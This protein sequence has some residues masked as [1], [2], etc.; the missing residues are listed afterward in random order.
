MKNSLSA[1]LPLPPTKKKKNTRLIQIFQ[2]FQT[3]GNHG[4]GR[5]LSKKIIWIL[6]SSRH[7]IFSPIFFFLL[8]ISLPDEN[9]GLRLHQFDRCKLIVPLLSRDYVTS[10]EHMEELH[11][12]LCRHRFSNEIILFPIVV[13]KLPPTPVHPH[14]LFT[15]FNV[16]DEVWHNGTRPTFSCLNTAAIVIG[17]ILNSKPRV[18]TSFRTLLSIRELVEWTEIMTSSKTD[19][20]SDHNE[21]LQLPLCYFSKTIANHTVEASP[22]SPVPLLDNEET[23]P[24]Q[25]KKEF[26][27]GKNASEKSELE[28]NEIAATYPTSDSI[29]NTISDVDTDMN[30]D[31]SGGSVVQLKL[32]EGMDD[33]Q[34]EQLLAELNNIDIG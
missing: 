14:L 28:I 23:L 15:L 19:N 17:N 22:S 25:D 24:L 18:L 12:A 9:A 29:D 13:D 7:S 5:L 30:I 16:N 1:S 2:V 8:K 3:Y 20:S 31:V 10:P 33:D 4:S 27:N 32:A 11:T 6:R 34:T 26:D 21:S